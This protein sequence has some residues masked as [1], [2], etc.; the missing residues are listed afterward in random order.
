MGI[1]STAGAAIAGLA[2]AGAGIAGT[3]GSAVSNRRVSQLNNAFNERMLQKQMDYNTEM[4]ERQLG[5]QWKMYEDAKQYNS[6]SAQ[7]ERLEAAGLNA[8]LLMS[9]ANTGSVQSMNAPSSQGINTPQGQ[10]IPTDY[11]GLSQIV[12]NAIGVASELSQKRRTDAETYGLYIENQYKGAQLLANLG[13][14]LAEA[15]NTEA[16]TVTEN[17]MRN[18]NAQL[19][20][21]QISLTQQRAETEKFNSKVRAT[22]SLIAAQNLAFLPIQ[23]KMQMA[24]VCSSISY[25]LAQKELT[26]KQTLH[27]IDKI[28]ETQARVSLTTQQVSTERQLTAKAGAEAQQARTAANFDAATFET[29][30][31]LIKEELIKIIS[32][33]K[34]P[35]SFLQFFGFGRKKDFSGID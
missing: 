23:Q 32:E 2:G 14:T 29:R 30:K 22:E 28:A 16:R 26:E 11:S 15:K 3:V 7:R 17:L 35:S 9:G 25:R 6:A 1:L 21:G 20:Q 27:E 34:L 24:D 19:V 12:G 8:G 10:N 18:L 13:K 5:D 4:Y 33:Q 31:R